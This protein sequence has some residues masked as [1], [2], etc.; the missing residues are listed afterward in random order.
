[1]LL[2]TKHIRIE[3][4][5]L[6]VGADILHLLDEPKT[7]SRLWDD[8]Q[9]LRGRMTMRR[10]TFDRFT[11]A[12]ALLFSLNTLEFKRGRLLRVDAQ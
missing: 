8:F 3:R 12:I 4:S 5:L 1:M 10:V 6:G 7:V 9:E 2:P 11:L